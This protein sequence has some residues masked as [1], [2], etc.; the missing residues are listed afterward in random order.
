M[1]SFASFASVIRKVRLLRQ[2]QELIESELGSVKFYPVK[3]CSYTKTIY[4]PLCINEIPVIRSV[5]PTFL[6]VIPPPFYY[7][8]FDSSD[9][10]L[11]ALSDEEERLSYE[12]VQDRLLQGIWTKSNS[13][14]V[15]IISSNVS[16]SFIN[17]TFD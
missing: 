17:I 8:L 5:T 14:C 2:G 7:S 11:S 3:V 6:K 4:S 1:A 15:S 13:I 12:L 10:L 9:Y 16:L